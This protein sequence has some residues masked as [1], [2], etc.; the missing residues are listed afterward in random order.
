MSMLHIPVKERVAD[1]DGYMTP[2]WL[3]LMQI[4]GRT[5]GFDLATGTAGAPTVFDSYARASFPAVGNA[6]RMIRRTDGPRGIWMDTGTQWISLGF[7][8]FNAVEYGFASGGADNTAAWAA[9]K[10][11]INALDANTYRGTR[12]IF[13]YGKFY[14]PQGMVTDRA[15]IMEGSGGQHA[16][17]TSYYPGNELASTVLLVDGGQ[18]GFATNKTTHGFFSILRNLELRA[19]AKSGAADGVY[20]P[21]R[22]FLDNVHVVGF[23]RHAVNITANSADAENSN[24]W[25]VEHSRLEDCGGDALHLRGTDVNA[26]CAFMNDYVGCAGWGISAKTSYGNEFIGGN[27]EGNVTGGIQSGESNAYFLCRNAFRGIYVEGGQVNDVN[28]PALIDNCSTLG[29]FTAGNAPIRIADGKIFVGCTTYGPWGDVNAVSAVSRGIV[30]DLGA[31]ISVPPL[32]LAADGRVDHKMSSYAP[33]GTFCWVEMATPSGGGAALTGAS[34]EVLA[35]KMRAFGTGEATAEGASD[36][37]Q[38]VIDCAKYNGVTAIQVLSDAANMVAFRNGGTNWAFIKANGEYAARGVGMMY[39][40]A[41]VARINTT[42]KA[43][44]TYGYRVDV[45]TAWNEAFS[46][47]ASATLVDHGI[48]GYTSSNT[49]MFMEK[50]EL[51][52]GVEINGL[53]GRNMVATISNATPGVVTSNGHGLENN[54]PVKLATTGALPAGLTA[55]TTYFVANKAANTFELSASHGGG[56]IATSSAGS[57]VHTV[58]VGTSGAVVKGYGTV[59]DTTKTSAAHAAVELVAIL[60]NGTGPSTFAAGDNMWGVSNA[61]TMRII[62]TG[63]GSIYM[64][65]G[66]LN[67]SD[68]VNVAL[69]TATGTKIGTATSQK[70]GFWNTTPIV[71]PTSAVAAATFA[72]NTSAIAND[73]ATFDGYTIGQV[74]K[75]LRNMGALA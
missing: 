70:I 58:Y 44:S 62:V 2:R 23:S 59:P 53:T 26:G 25:R 43:R 7:E 55:G 41:D 27:V 61:G 54:Q 10:A 3:G 75:A 56:S 67:L 47:L 71:Q 24:N 28:A 38:F 52:G 21:S 16:G 19:I 37:G 40:G 45:G 57:G 9:M 50:A 72:A 6:G 34:E 32:A 39:W 31:S 8:W 68:A 36:D 11:E 13:P 5:Y 74:V 73:T 65:A 17:D 46:M 33:T 48:T 66:N 12:I 42:D 60:K 51:S 15:I 20:A 22:V 49:C 4:L 18:T 14:I 64:L 35:L 1:K 30:V 69:G 29:G 63:D